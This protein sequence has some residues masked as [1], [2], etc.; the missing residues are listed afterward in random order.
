MRWPLHELLE[1][2]RIRSRMSSVVEPEGGADRLRVGKPDVRPAGE[3]QTSTR[4]G[5]SEPSSSPWIS[6]VPM[7]ESPES[8]S[9]SSG[10]QPD[11]RAAAPWSM[12]A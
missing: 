6:S 2:A 9:S 3:T 7:R 5:S 10:A 8:V 12:R 4:S 11:A 1:P